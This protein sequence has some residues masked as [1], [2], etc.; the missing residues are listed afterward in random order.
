M[1]HMLLTEIPRPSRIFTFY[2]FDLKLDWRAEADPQ[3]Y[4]ELLQE[5]EFSS[6][7]L[8]SSLVSRESSQAVKV[9]SVSRHNSDVR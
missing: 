3:L 5:T 8:D 6:Q 7:H 4:F 1:W 9:V 2:D